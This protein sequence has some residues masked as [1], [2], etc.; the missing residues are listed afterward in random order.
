MPDDPLKNA[1]DALDDPPVENLGPAIRARAA[2]RQRRRRVP[3]VWRIAAALV[4]AGVGVS[5]AYLAIRTPA[6]EL[7]SGRWRGDESA[8]EVLG[9]SYVIEGEGD[10]GAET[11]RPVGPSERII[12][13]VH[14]DRH[15]FLCLDEQGDGAWQRIYPGAE[16]GWRVS[17]GRHWPGGDEPLSF[18]TEHGPGT[19]AYRVLADPEYADCSSPSAEQRVEVHWQ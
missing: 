14:T 1:F 16:E 10:L 19:R 9:L 18:G 12:F 11:A 7:G 6:D 8:G 13:T 3:A 5:I 17:A 4:V 2:A 15:A